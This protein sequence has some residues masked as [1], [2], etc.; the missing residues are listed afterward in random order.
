MGGAGSWLE[1]SR[2]LPAVVR[3]V[4]VGETDRGPVGVQKAE[5]SVTL[6]GWLLIL[7]GVGLQVVVPLNPGLVGPGTL[8]GFPAQVFMIFLGVLVLWAG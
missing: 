5:G 7:L 6:I 4:G 2:A 3:Q 1:V 8:A